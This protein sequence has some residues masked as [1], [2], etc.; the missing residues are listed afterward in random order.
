MDGVPAPIGLTGTHACVSLGAPDGDV[1][2][3]AHD[4]CT[5]LL[6]VAGHGTTVMVNGQPCR[7]D[8]DTIVFVNPWEPYHERSEYNEQVVVLRLMLHTGWRLGI[9]QG[10]LPLHSRPFS[11]RQVRLNGEVRRRVLALVSA[12]RHADESPVVEPD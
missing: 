11:E 7:T 8:I 12:L 6:T 9:P 5:C 2:V 4:A 3:H 1:A 10:P